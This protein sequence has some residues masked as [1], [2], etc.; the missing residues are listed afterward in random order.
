MRKNL[1]G[2]T[3]AAVLV[4]ALGCSSS[5]TYPPSDSYAR[6]AAA[7]YPELALAESEGTSYDPG[8]AELDTTTSLSAEG[9]ETAP[10]PSD[11]WEFTLTPYLFM[12]AIS[13]D[14]EVGPLTPSV[15]VSFSDVLDALQF[16]MAARFEGHKNRWGFFV[17][18]LYMD[19]EADTTL[20]RI[21]IEDE[22]QMAAV[23]FGASYVLWESSRKTGNKS[24][25]SL[26][27]LGGGRWWY[28]KNELDMSPGPD[29]DKSKWWIDPII[30]PRVTWRITDKI[31]ANVR[32]DWGGFGIG[33][34]SDSSF[35]IFG[36]V[37]V[38]LWKNKSLVLGY[39]YL[40]IEH[41]RADLTFKGPWVG[42]AFDF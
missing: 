37:N 5:P 4:F 27:I 35:G 11:Q 31:A 6:D 16:A 33:S 24:A 23:E 14:V 13:G 41:G 2:L 20:G 7:A 17:D 21:S 10:A 25:L 38:E 34:A 28:V 32:A 12:L 19:L 1:M 40:E 30:G 8:A 9:A 36:A 3:T 26:E 22:L 29:V 39:R 18:G 15:D 42:F